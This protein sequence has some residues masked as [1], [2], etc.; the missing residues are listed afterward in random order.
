MRRRT[1]RAARRQWVVCVGWAGAIQRRAWVR[2]SDKAGTKEWTGFCK[3]AVVQVGQEDVVHSIEVP[4]GP[5]RRDEAHARY[6]VVAGW[7]QL[8]RGR[9]GDEDLPFPERGFRGM[10]QPEGYNVAVFLPHS[11]RGRLLSCAV[12]FCRRTHT[13]AVNDAERKVL[14]VQG[15]GEARRTAAGEYDWVALHPEAMREALQALGLASEGDCTVPQHGGRQSCESSVLDCDAVSSSV[16]A[17]QGCEALSIVYVSRE[18]GVL[19][20]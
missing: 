13:I 20:P 10:M 7:R 9:V 5:A 1:H 4:M 3:V 6:D 15:G 8:T 18:C 2:H 14:K 11:K 17:S 19:C 16:G 12:K